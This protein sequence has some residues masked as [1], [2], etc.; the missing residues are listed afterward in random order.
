MDNLFLTFQKQITDINIIEQ[1]PFV[2]N[3][4]NPSDEF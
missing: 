3:M 4:R 1:M 2:K